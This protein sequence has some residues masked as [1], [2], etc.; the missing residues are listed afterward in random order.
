MRQATDPFI[1][2]APGANAAAVVL[3]RGLY[4]N[5]SNCSIGNSD[6]ST[7]FNPEILH[8]TIKA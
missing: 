1:L 7:C 6:L 3:T 2:R 5:R 8:R 4:R